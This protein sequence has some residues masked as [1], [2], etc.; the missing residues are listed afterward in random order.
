MRKIIITIIAIIF[1]IASL[2]KVK[3]QSQT[4]I[5]SADFP[6]INVLTGVNAKISLGLWRFEPFVQYGIYLQMFEERMTTEIFSNETSVSQNEYYSPKFSGRA[7]FDFGTKFRITNRNRIK[8]G[9]AI[10]YY[11]F[12]P[13]DRFYLGY[14]H[15]VN[16]SQRI[17]LDLSIQY[18]FDWLDLRRGWSYWRNSGQT[19]IANYQFV[20]FRTRLNYEIFRNLNLNVQLG[21]TRRYNVRYAWTED[22]VESVLTRNFINFSI[23][24]HYHIPLVGGQPQQPIPPRPPR[25]RVAPHQRALPCPPG[26]MRHLR[27][28]DRPSSVFNHPSGR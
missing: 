18:G 16:L 15:K 19:G 14:I 28:W 25:Q 1:L 27:S 22:V 11:G 26:Q 2:E 24:I 8:I 4:V 13:W 17:S 3:G 10:G 9:I 7:V 12:I 5:T 20:S 21:Y 23:G 6:T